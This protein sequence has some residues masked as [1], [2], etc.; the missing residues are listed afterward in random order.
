EPDRHVERR[1]RLPG[2]RVVDLPGHTGRP[3]FGDRS[4]GDGHLIGTRRPRLRF[5]GAL[6]NHVRIVRP[7]VPLPRTPRTRPS[8]QVGAGL[9]DRPTSAETPKPPTATRRSHAMSRTGSIVIRPPR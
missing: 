1:G 7:D 8:P 4:R 2:A 3:T 9:W 6:G 5:T